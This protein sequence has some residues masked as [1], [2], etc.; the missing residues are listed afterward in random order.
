[1]RVAICDDE[2]MELKRTKEILENSYKSLDLLISTYEDGKKL[3]KAIDTTAYD[4]IILDIEMPFIDGLSVARK[5]RELGQNTAIVFLTSH[6]EYA[7]KGYEVN[8]LRYLTKPVKEKQ[9]LEIIN[10]LVEQNMM[11]KK[12]MVKDS[13]DM[14]LIGVKDIL[15]MEARNQDI[16]IYTKDWEY[17]RR[18]N[19]KDYEQELANYFFVRCHRSYLV[20][21]AHIV[22]LSGKDI[23][24]DN[25]KMI[26]L[27]RTK[28]KGV[29][30][31][32]ISYTKRSAI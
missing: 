15:Y 22:R 26:P 19:I 29:R 2:F 11:D 3:L 28:E 4:L 9:L 31:A 5:L 13:E 10:Y 23:M 7:L 16:L 24:L 8:A 18:Y 27:S 30:E 20:N 12:I 25:E 21:L 32:L 1:M 17:I 14:V 6:I